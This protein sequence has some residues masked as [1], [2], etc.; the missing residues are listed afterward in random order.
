[1]NLRCKSPALRGHSLCFWHHQNRK[2]KEKFTVPLLETEQ[3][4]QATLSQVLRELHEG[5]I[6][7]KRANS[8]FYGLSLAMYNVRRMSSSHDSDHITELPPAMLEPFDVIT[9]EHV[10]TGT[11][12]H[13]GTGVLACSSSR[14]EQ[15][16]TTA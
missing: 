1:T 12:K 9:D 8:M 2:Y 16:S 13:V 5:R 11:D 3:A 6:D 7:T 10:G 14:S 4:I 15:E